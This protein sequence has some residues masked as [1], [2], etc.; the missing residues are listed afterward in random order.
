MSVTGFI[1][2]EDY[3]GETTRVNVHIPDITALNWAGV[4]QDLD[5]IADAIA[6]TA[7]P[8]I[9]GTVRKVGYTQEWGRDLSTAVT[10]DEAQREEKWLVVYQDTQEHLDV[11]GA[12]DN[13]GYGKI[14]SF[15]IGTA[16]LT[17]HLVPGTD[18]ADMENADVAELVSKLE[19]NIASPYNKNGTTHTCRVLKIVHVGRNT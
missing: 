14:F 18:L 12:I 2:I 7:N 5:E 17:D 19:A 8:M 4:T 11:A 16:L 6:S 3:S 9:R 10:D 13:P 15:E 1:V